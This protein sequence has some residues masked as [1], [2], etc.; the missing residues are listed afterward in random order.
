MKGRNRQAY[1]KAVLKTE[2]APADYPWG[3]LRALRH[4]Q[5]ELTETEFYSLH[6]KHL[7]LPQAEHFT[8][9]HRE[10]RPYFRQEKGGDYKDSTLSFFNRTD[11]AQRRSESAIASAAYRAGGAPLQQLPMEEVSDYTKGRRDRFGNHA[12]APCAVGNIS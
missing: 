8:V 9:C 2:D 1:L 12:A 11:K 5:K 6:G 4:R 3:I 10:P 7:N